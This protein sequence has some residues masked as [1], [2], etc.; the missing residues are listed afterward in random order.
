MKKSKF[1]VAV[2]LASILL[3]SC[4]KSSDEAK[5]ED[6]TTQSIN[7]TTTVQFYKDALTQLEEKILVLQQDAYITSAT[8]ELKI[9]E[10]EEYIASLESTKNDTESSTNQNVVLENTKIYFEYSFTSDGAVITKYT[11]TTGSV[12]IPS[13]I[14]GRPVIKISEYAFSE[15]N[16]KNVI[17]PEGI[18]EI[19]WFAFYKC[20][21]LENIYVPISV[22]SIGYGA[23]DYCASS[24]TIFCPSDS[25][26]QKYAQS[27]GIKCVNQ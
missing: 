21:F 20:P 5:N 13:S 8:Y 6:T 1:I 16:V 18:R 12:E 3:S 27:F 24:L 26:A 14:E 22:T 25:Y 10:L 2:L 4:A 19:D 17:L 7:D 11:G 9:R 15:T 23:F